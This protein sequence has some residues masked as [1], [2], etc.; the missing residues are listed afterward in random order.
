MKPFWNYSPFNCLV[1]PPPLGVVGL[2]LKTS[3][4]SFSLLGNTDSACVNNVATFARPQSGID[5]LLIF[6]A[7]PPVRACQWLPCSHHHLRTAVI[8]INI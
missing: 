4:S 6:L 3:P 1:D 2:R 7:S 5:Q 8:K